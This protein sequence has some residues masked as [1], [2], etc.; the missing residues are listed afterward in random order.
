MMLVQ[1]KILRQALGLRA[2]GVLHVG[3]HRA[4]E[5]EL[6]SN[7]GWGPV[8]W[9][10]VQPSLVKLLEERF[11]GSDDRVFEG[12]AWSE[13]GL[14]LDLNLASN[15]QSS[16]VYLSEM[17]SAYYPEIEFTDKL[18]V[19]TVRLDELLPEAIEFQFVNLDI[20]GAELEALR[21]LGQRLQA[22]EVVYCEVNREFL[23]RD[24]PLVSELDAYLRDFRF[25]RC[26]TVWTHAGWGDA[27]YVKARSRPHELFLKT[28]MPIVFTILKFFADMRN[29]QKRQTRLV[30]DF[31]VALKRRFSRVRPSL[32][33]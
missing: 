14:R 2:R 7:V 26:F 20:Q 22:A 12:C 5:R 29:S 18:T 25:I 30:L 28:V 17:H 10:E 31:L 32:T 6:Y 19:A 24:I 13:T 16:S 4:E 9:V 33:E 15:S 27:V 1:P 23:Y 8:A 3:A 21:G 11:S